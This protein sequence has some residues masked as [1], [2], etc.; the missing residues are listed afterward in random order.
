MDHAHN[1]KNGILLAIITM[2]ILYIAVSVYGVIRDMGTGTTVFVISS[3]LPPVQDINK[4]TPFLEKIKY[5][6]YPPAKMIV[7][8][9]KNV[10]I[11]GRVVC[12]DGSPYAN[13]LV[14]LRSEPRFIYTD[15][16]GYFIFNNVE[17]GEHIIS[18]LNQNREVQVS[19]RVIINR[20][21]EIADA[22]LVQT[23]VDTYV[24]EVAVD[25]KLLEIVLEV[26]RDN[27]GQ[28]SGLLIVKPEVN[29][30]ER[31]LPGEQPVIPPVTPPVTP[32]V[33]PPVDAL[34]VYSTVDTRNFNKAP[35]SAA[36]INIFG[37]GKRIAPG[38]TGVYKF[39][40]DNTGNPFAIYYDIDLL[41]TNN[42]LNIPMEYRLYNNRTN[43]YVNGDANWHTTAEIR[44]IT[45][46]PAAR[47]SMT[48]S[49]KT[50]YTL[51]WF[52]DDGG[53]I[54]NSYAEQHAG[55]AVCT[56]TIRVS[57]QRKRK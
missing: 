51:E 17:D 45:A 46:N 52:W 11:K 6:F 5:F 4:A 15:R 2:I 38:M 7:P 16:E 40:I 28:L 54:D 23:G 33:I 35:V 50:D 20:N 12:T 47:L 13:G 48:D 53:S 19:C 44:T 18:V 31:Y 39:T 36:D 22:V 27:S 26:Q 49:M 55:E 42:S 37:S 21:L 8:V 3:S 29:V 32:P 14:E 25:V 10:N 9:E 56:L 43:S 41:E 24:L 34:T 57:A 30:L 1:R